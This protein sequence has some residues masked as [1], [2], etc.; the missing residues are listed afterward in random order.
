M[1][2]NTCH[3]VNND[4]NYVFEVSGTNELP[5]YSFYAVFK[6]PKTVSK[7]TIKTDL[8]WV[9]KHIKDQL[10]TSIDSKTCQGCINNKKFKDATDVLD[11]LGIIILSIR[12]AS[13]STTCLIK[14]LSEDRECMC[15]TPC[16]DC[17]KKLFTIEKM[18]AMLKDLE[19]TMSSFPERFGH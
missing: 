19:D 6:D 1:A 8:V 12:K 4:N 14:C 10:K 18:D 13:S 15:G 5:N 17:R 16:K 11:G 2:G 3:L 9:K 7:D